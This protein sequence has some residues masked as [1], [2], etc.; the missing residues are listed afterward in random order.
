MPSSYAQRR[1]AEIRAAPA[2]KRRFRNRK[3]L[4][5]LA[6]E[7]FEKETPMP[8]SPMAID[9]NDPVH[10]AANNYVRKLRRKEN[11]SASWFDVHDAFVMGFRAGR[12]K[13]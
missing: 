5:M 12:T 7:K 3:V 9:M 6:L 2:P 8:T 13:P 10:V 11:R 4:L 1:L